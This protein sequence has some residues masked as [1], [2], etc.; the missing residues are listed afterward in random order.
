MHPQLS[1]FLSS[2]K[3]VADQ[4]GG[5]R[6]LWQ[7]RAILD[8]LI[9]SHRTVDYIP[10]DFDD[11]AHTH[12]FCELVIY[13][14][15]AVEYLA[16]HN[17]YSPRFGDIFLAAP[18]E[19]HG[20][21]L[22]T[23]SRYDRYVLWF[24]AELLDGYHG[25]QEALA[26]FFPGRPYGSRNLLRP[27]AREVP[28][29]IALLREADTDDEL[30]AWSALLR[31]FHRLG[32]LWA[33]SAPAAIP[34]VSLPEPLEAALACIAVDYAAIRSVAEIAERVHVSGEHL[35]RLFTRQFGIPISEYLRRHRL[36]ES[37]RLLLDG[38][39]VTEACYSV[40]F[41][42][43]SHFVRC[44]R[45]YVGMTPAKYRALSE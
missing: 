35:S 7:D 22:I 5:G 18:G 15:G 1:A 29:L 25:G 2:E 3:Y 32:R 9:F 24:P 27:D 16:E 23:A 40:G 31:F 4:Q 45:T 33:D 44:F 30:I 6:P 20:A 11:L 8:S 42:N 41:S 28:G 21:H 37:K 13:L 36:N 39:S 43:I 38:A 12:D 10:G 14:S 34:P 26:P 19:F 17:V